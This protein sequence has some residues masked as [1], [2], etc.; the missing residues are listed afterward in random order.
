MST[1]AAPDFLA[2]ELEEKRS[3]DS[4]LFHVIPVPLEQSVSYGRGTKDGPAAILEA[5]QQLEAWDGRSTPLEL[6]IHT[7][8]FIDCSGKLRQVLQRIRQRTALALG[9]GKM[10][11]L[12]GGEHTVTLGALEAVCA[13]FPDPV[14]LFQLD[15]HAD[16]RES[17]EGSRFSHACVARR[18]H[19]DL[20]MKL[21]QFGVR[22]LS[23]EEV[24]YREEHHIA[25]LDAATFYQSASRECS[26]PPTFPERIYLTLDVDGLDPSVLRATGT[27]V[28]GGPGW[29]DT[30][31]VLEEVIKGRTVVGFDVVELAPRPEDHASSF[32]AAL[33]VYSVMG[34]IQRN[35]T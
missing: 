16:L 25:H 26:L 17:Y 33:L 27:P 13:F 5:S 23:L 32:A 9:A 21:F 8:D 7:T 24:N 12:L 35:R 11:V 31:A 14:G 3:P 18:A 30:L 29:H 2:S 20:G 28:P 34:L 1:P 4:A 15:A 10:P 6:G 22:A 19:A